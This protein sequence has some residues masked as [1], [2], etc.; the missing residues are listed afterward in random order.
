MIHKNLH[1]KVLIGVL[2]LSAFLAMSGMAAADQSMG[3]GSSYSNDSYKEMGRNPDSMNQ[4]DMNM[5]GS[6]GAYMDSG[7]QQS[8]MQEAWQESTPPPQMPSY[9]LGGTAFIGEH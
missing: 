3:P 1:P 7:Q 9:G 8:R 6:A 4:E 5:S 2:L